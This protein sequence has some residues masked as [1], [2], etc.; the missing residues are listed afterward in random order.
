[1]SLYFVLWAQLDRCLTLLNLIFLR[2]FLHYYHVLRTYHSNKGPFIQNVGSSFTGEGVINEQN[3]RH[4]FLW[5]N[6][7]HAGG[8][9]QK[10]G[11]IIDVLS[12]HLLSKSRWCVGP[13]YAKECSYQALCHP[14]FSTSLAFPHKTHIW[15]A[16]DA[17]PFFRHSQRSQSIHFRSH[18][19]FSA[20]SVSFQRPRRKY[21]IGQ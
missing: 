19:F 3:M 14:R 11:K 10:S 6:F 5:Y 8:R 7:Q 12:G 18:I 20:P 21:A 15:Q 16:T 1:M 2:T 13:F 4:Y 9:C 17:S